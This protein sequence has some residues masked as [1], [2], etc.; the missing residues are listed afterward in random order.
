MPH[1]R[2]FLDA[3]E[4]DLKRE[5]I[6]TES[7]TVAVQEP[8]LSFV[9]DATQ[10]LYEQLTKSLQQN[11]A[12]EVGASLAAQ[13][14]QHNLLAAHYPGTVPS[15]AAN[16][17]SQSGPSE[18]YHR[19]SQSIQS[20]VPI[21]YRSHSRE[22]Q[23]SVPPQPP[24]GYELQRDDSFHQGRSFNASSPED[25][26]K[27]ADR[28]NG[29]ADV[30]TEDYMRQRTT[31]YDEA[32]QMPFRMTGHD[33]LGNNDQSAQSMPSGRFVSAYPQT[34]MNDFDL[35]FDQPVAQQP[36][37]HYTEE[38]QNSR[39]DAPGNFQSFGGEP[40]NLCQY[41]ASP[42]ARGLSL[43]LN[44]FEGSPTYKQRRRRQSIL[45]SIL[46]A[47]QTGQAQTP[48]T[49]RAATE[50]HGKADRN[51]NFAQTTSSTPPEGRYAADHRYEQY[52][53]NY[54]LSYQE[55]LEIAELERCVSRA[56]SERSATGS[57]YSIKD[58]SCP[59]PSC[60]RP[61]KRQE[62]LRRHVRSHTQE[63]PYLCDGCDKR[64]SSS[65][66]LA[67]HRRTHQMP[68][69]NSSFQRFISHN[70]PDQ[71]TYNVQD[72]FNYEDMSEYSGS[73]VYRTDESQGSNFVPGSYGVSMAQ[74]AG[75]DDHTAP[76][77][78]DFSVEGQHP[79]PQ[80]FDL[81]SAKF[82]ASLNPLS[83]RSYPEAPS[84]DLE[85]SPHATHST[86]SG[87]SSHSHAYIPTSGIS[88]F[89]HH[90][91]APRMMIG[92]QDWH[93]ND[94]TPRQDHFSSLTPTYNS[95]GVSGEQRQW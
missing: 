45:T 57:P 19:R 61:F 63:R 72:N 33:Q 31:S 66:N 67:Q 3:L 25:F 11:A 8:A 71:H 73:E 77:M 76:G 83:P 64:F 50:P 7:T 90:T 13:Q 65:D 42:R 18:A 58:Y 28:S 32:M 59:Y 47:E 81:D 93:D 14:A 4:R 2:L 6:G 30:Q 10:S 85:N 88:S 53:D 69:T 54:E 75:S 26:H 84:H 74:T 40:E 9:F 89:T 79:Q 52:Q 49:V 16:F 48:G 41:S 37:P 62:H 35:G 38:D 22:Y 36:Q 21:D 56:G 91:A 24:L 12:S 70:D 39:Y 95:H 1:D 34:S 55:D 82:H 27:Y 87:E 92:A 80:S 5:R 23:S 78:S 15:F 60:G 44:M 51:P 68:N 43:N 86:V 46:L 20:A 94:V 17:A 29:F